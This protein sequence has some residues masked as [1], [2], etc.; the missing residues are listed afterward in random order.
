MPDRSTGTHKNH[1]HLYEASSDIKNGRASSPLCSHSWSELRRRHPHPHARTQSRDSDQCRVVTTEDLQCVTKSRRA[2]SAYTDAKHSFVKDSSRI[3]VVL[4]FSST[5]SPALLLGQTSRLFHRA[6]AAPAASCTSTAHV[7]PCFAR[8]CT[9]PSL[10]GLQG[11]VDEDSSSNFVHR[12]DL[13][14]QNKNQD[15]LFF[16]V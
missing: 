15:T 9:L 2:E 7:R 16:L 5:R 14:K 10:K 8:K 3:H 1:T 11:R 12:E 13:E 4:R 6:L